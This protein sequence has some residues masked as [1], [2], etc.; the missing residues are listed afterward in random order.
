MIPQVVVQSR[1]VVSDSFEEEWMDQIQIVFE[2]V[3]HALPKNKI[4]EVRI[5]GRNNTSLVL[6]LPTC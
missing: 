3:A 2:L 5:V 1:L 6:L 4:L